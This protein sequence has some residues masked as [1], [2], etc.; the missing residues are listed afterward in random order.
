MYGE[1]AMNRGRR[2]GE[3]RG[4]APEHGS[5]RS[6]GVCEAARASEHC[7]ATPVATWVG[8]RACTAHGV[9]PR[10]CFDSV[11]TGHWTLR[12]PRSEAV[13]LLLIESMITAETGCKMT[14]LTADNK[15]VQGRQK[16]RECL[17][18]PGAHPSEPRA[19]VSSRVHRSGST[20]G[21]GRARGHEL[22]VSP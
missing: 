13:S 7:Y 9:R 8:G 11:D 5:C 6:E 21:D 4:S 1:R 2:K 10:A 22:L 3:G 12:A 16:V 19:R 20:S 15:R 17:P 14:Y 18:L